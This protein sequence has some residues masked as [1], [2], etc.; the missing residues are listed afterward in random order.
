VPLVSALCR[1][2]LPCFAS[3]ASMLD[4]GAHALRW[5]DVCVGVSVCVRVCVY[6]RGQC[7]AVASQSPND[8]DVSLHL[9]RMMR[10]TQSLH[11]QSPHDDCSQQL[12]NFF[13]LL[14]CLSFTQTKQP[15]VVAHKAYTWVLLCWRTGLI[16]KKK[17]KKRKR[18]NDVQAIT[19]SCFRAPT[20]AVNR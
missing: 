17:K 1:R 13:A 12:P 2:V 19:I 9:T 18:K 8:K 15:C 16:K 10:H 5:E 7:P 3:L 20:S 6:A 4:G 14:L 11:W